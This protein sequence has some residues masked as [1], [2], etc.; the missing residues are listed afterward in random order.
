MA[1]HGRREIPAALGKVQHAPAACHDGN[2]PT[3]DPATGRTTPPNA[4]PGF[5][6]VRAPHVGVRAPGSINGRVTG[7][8]TGRTA[9]SLPIAMA[10]GVPVRLPLSAITSVDISRGRSRP[11]GAMTGAR[12]GAA[13]SACCRGSLP[14]RGA[15]CRRDRPRDVGRVATGGFRRATSVCRQRRE[16]RLGG[17]L[18]HFRNDRER[19]HRMRVVNVPRPRVAAKKP[20]ASGL[21]AI[22]VRVSPRRAP[23]S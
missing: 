10:S 14:S 20:S 23:Q 15:S 5:L 9:D 13:G 19:P 11:T 2:P 22:G 7:T 17:R 18:R 12:S 8:V 21:S 3:P 6:H 4:P 1:G 16:P